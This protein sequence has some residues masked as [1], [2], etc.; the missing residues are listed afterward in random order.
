MFS[1]KD[2]PRLYFGALS[3][4]SRPAAMLV[5]VLLIVPLASLA[6]VRQ[7][8]ADAPSPSP[9]ALMKEYRERFDQLKPNDVQGHY[10][11]AE[12][13]RDQNASSL[14][15]KQSEYVLRL[16]P[17]NEG[18]RGLYRL[19][20]DQIKAQQSQTMPADGAPTPVSVDGEFLTP[21]QIQKLKWAEFLD[22]NSPVAV[23]NGR[24]R[25]PVGRARPGNRHE[26][27]LQVRYDGKVLDEFFELM[28]GTPGFSSREDRGLLLRLSPTE[29]VQL[30]RRLTGDRFQSRIEIINDPLVFR[31]FQRVMPLV[32]NG[33]G[34]LSCHGGSDAQVWR[35]R[36]T[37]TRADQ[38]LYT[39]FL[40]LNRVLRGSQR[41]V[42]RE[43]PEDS[44]LIQFAL[45]RVQS[46]HPHPESIPILFPKGRDDVRYQTVMSWI[47]TLQMPEP[48]T[49]I[50]LPGYPE[51]PPPQFGNVRNEQGESA[52]KQPV[53][54]ENPS[55]AGEP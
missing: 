37:R 48:R 35:W 38:N 39:N 9:Q 22:V 30:I 51:P 3:R 45:P 52:V 21:G 49:G 40:I 16:D 2:R 33:C 25:A 20:V 13:C 31:Q 42:N 55:P 10:A 17:A 36:T 15:L 27:F 43:K 18:A 50:V 28:S 24:G 12:W 32:T 11:L 8:S 46:Y 44:F 23:A 6:Q 4:Y 19:A 34:S 41:L 5:C 1:H 53:S 54:K 14:L 47:Q 7:P 29:Q 26:E